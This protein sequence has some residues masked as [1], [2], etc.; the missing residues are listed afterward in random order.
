MT[1]ANANTAG[2]SEIS[3]DDHP[4]MLPEELVESYYRWYLNSP[5]QPGARKAL[6]KRRLLSPAFIRKLQGQQGLG[7]GQIDLLFCSE[8]LPGSV[9]VQEALMEGDR[10]EVLLRTDRDDLLRILLQS[11]KSAWRIVDVICQDD[12]SFGKPTK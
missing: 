11:H 6:K 5:G 4:S 10:A 3:F 2:E 7:L 9:S 12:E 1:N 8:Q